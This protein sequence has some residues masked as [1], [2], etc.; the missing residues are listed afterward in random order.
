MIWL[1]ENGCTALNNSKL[2]HIDYSNS[3]PCNLHY[4]PHYYTQFF[5]FLKICFAGKFYHYLFSIIRGYGTGWC[6]S[7]K[8]LKQ[9]TQNEEDVIQ[10][11]QTDNQ[12][13]V[14]R[15]PASQ[16][17]NRA[18]RIAMLTYSFYELD[19]RVRRYAE[20]LVKQGHYVDIISLRR[21]K[22]GKYNELKGVRIFRI[23]ERTRDEKGKFRYLSRMLKFFIKSANFLNRSHLRNRYDLIHVHSVPDFE[24]FAALVPKLTGAKII[25]DIHDPVPDFFSAKFG[26]KNNGI[27]FKALKLTERI[28][29]HF[30]DHVITVSDYWR[31]I[32]RNRSGLPNEKVTSIVNYPDPQIFNF[33]NK[34][35]GTRSTKRFAILY[36]GTLNKHCGLHI[37]LEAIALL[38][39]TIP[40]IQLHIYGT[41]N[42][43]STL[44]SM[45][46][47]F[48]LEDSVL[49][50]DSVPIDEVPNLMLNADI[51]I[52]LLAGD[53]SYSKQALNVKLFEFLA[54]GLPAIASRVDSIEKYIGDGVAMLSIP[55]DPKDVAR[56]I[57][58]LYQNPGLRE[59]LRNAGLIYTM[60]NNW[61]SQ[62]NKYLSII[63][64][65]IM[66]KNFE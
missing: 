31:D 12:S 57:R 58:D 29:S 42:E 26:Y 11:D 18:L 43:E 44:R 65:I 54:M 47:K 10:G 8:F 59:E 19:N 56:C 60:K 1:Y 13:F 22:Q 40:N 14:S 61:Q 28:S 21:E 48:G 27:Y 38:Q 23:Q 5:E 4:T 6:A 52:A 33:E 63:S 3:K 55:N 15:N 9:S 64:K 49:F 62:A 36:P 37:V 16:P 51:G 7:D 32:I 17:L 30:A 2:D 53:N 34:K 35:K 45:V 24:V 66:K 46:K 50:N 25:L 41:G 20:T 39:G